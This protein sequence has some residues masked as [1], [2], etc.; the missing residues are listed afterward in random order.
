M[1]SIQTV[2]SDGIAPLDLDSMSEIDGGSI[3]YYVIP[4]SIYLAMTVAEH[5]LDFKRGIRTGY[6]A[7]LYHM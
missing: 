4:I 1:Y 2:P 7:A 5:W 3:P 6:R